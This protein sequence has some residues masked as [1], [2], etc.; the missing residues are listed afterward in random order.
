MMI[1]QYLL[2]SRFA[3]PRGYGQTGPKSKRAGYDSVAA[4]VSGLLHIT[5]PEEG[6]PVRPGVAMTDL[7]TGL[8]AYGAIMA[9][10]F[11]RYK[12]GKGMHVDCNLL[13][14]QASKDCV[15]K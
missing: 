6:E 2:F 4:A 1:F 5:G 3:L 8:Y 11:H 15:S 9:A 12:T 14:S 7:A 10:L 13:S